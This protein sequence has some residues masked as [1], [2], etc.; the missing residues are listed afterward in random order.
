MT[1]YTPTTEEVR[2]RYLSEVFPEDEAEFDRWLAE[3]K[4]EAWDEGHDAGVQLERLR[5]SEFPYGTVNA[6]PYREET[7]PVGGIHSNHCDD[8]GCLGCEC[9]PACD[10]YEETE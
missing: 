8:R 3:V 1:D 9:D 5:N 10:D 7:E 2:N 6:N 4:A